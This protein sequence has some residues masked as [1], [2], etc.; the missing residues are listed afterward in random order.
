MTRNNRSGLALHF[1][2]TQIEIIFETAYP[3]AQFTVETERDLCQELYL[4][5]LMQPDRIR[6]ASLLKR[7]KKHTRIQF[8]AA[9][10]HFT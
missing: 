2:D 1:K 9:I 4:L 3:G 5:V 8:S 10:I 7:K 6:A